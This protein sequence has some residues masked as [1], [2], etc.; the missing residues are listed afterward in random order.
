MAGLGRKV[1]A[2][3]DVLTAVDVNGY[4]M[5]QSVM[6]FDDA[7]ARTAAIGTPTEGMMTYTKDDNAVQVFDGSVFTAVDTTISSINASAVVTT[8]TASTALAYTVADTDQGKLLQFTGSSAVVTFSTATAFTAG[9]RVDIL[10]DG[11]GMTISAGTAVVMAGAGT[12][13]TAISFTPGE[14]YEAVT[15]IGLG[16]DAYRIIGNILAV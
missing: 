13:G 11:G 1:F 9:Q 4:L 8:L 7:A 10:N 5:D 12:L 2:A 15:V 3:N 6:V 14:Q 16:S